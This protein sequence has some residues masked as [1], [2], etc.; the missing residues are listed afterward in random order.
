MY[1]LNVMNLDYWYFN[2]NWVRWKNIERS[3]EPV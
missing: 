2:W 3:I 1:D